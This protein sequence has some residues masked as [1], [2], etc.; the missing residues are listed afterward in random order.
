MEGRRKEDGEGRKGREE[1]KGMGGEDRGKTFLLRRPTLN[2][3]LSS[4]LPKN[5][6]T[7]LGVLN[8]EDHVLRKLQE[9]TCFLPL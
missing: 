6:E 8:K 1:R 9:Q 3:G 2:S 7:I 4:T 5:S